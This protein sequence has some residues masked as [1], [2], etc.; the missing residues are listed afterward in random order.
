MPVNILNK[1]LFRYTGSLIGGLW[2]LL[3]LEHS[4]VTL[5]R[6]AIC[7]ERDICYRACGHYS[8]YKQH[9]Q[10]FPV[11]QIFLWWAENLLE[12]R[13]RRPGRFCNSSNRLWG[14]LDFSTLFTNNECNQRKSWHVNFHNHHHCT[15]RNHNEIPSSSDLEKHQQQP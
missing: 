3:T 1:G 14:E 5:M 15:S 12:S 13:S 11:C 9:N 8:Y 2:H 7:R 6:N 10:A 4:L